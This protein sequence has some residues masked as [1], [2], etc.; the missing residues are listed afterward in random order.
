M[1]DDGT[2]SMKEYVQEQ[3]RSLDARIAATAQAA[4][5]DSAKQ[6]DSL[7]KFMALQMSSTQTAITKAEDQ[8]N[9]RLEGM[10][11]FRDSLKD[12]AAKFVTKEE[13]ALQLNAQDKRIQILERHVSTGQGRSS[14]TT[15]LWA[16]AAS[17]FVSLV[18]AFAARAM[19]L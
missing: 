1:S 10:N 4:A 17:I 9:K 5:I 2:I 6:L 11:E 16:I 7:N 3:L 15:I 14:M 8:L 13:V 12:Q 19:K 18:A